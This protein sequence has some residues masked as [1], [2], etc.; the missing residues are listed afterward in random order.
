M[1][2]F[3]VTGKEI[4]AGLNVVLMDR[5]VNRVHIPRR[6]GE[7]ERW[8]AAVQSLDRA[9]IGSP[10]WQNLDLVLDLVLLGDADE[11]L[12]EL[13][14]GNQ[15]AVEKLDRG[16]IAK[17]RDPIGGRLPG[18]SFARV[19]SSATAMSGAMALPAAAAPRRPISSWTVATA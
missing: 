11:V 19:T 9:R 8:D 4:D 6:Y 14:V 3:D 15:A 12:E 16:S 17:L 13:W 18:M 10:E 1:G 2:F 5:L 7:G